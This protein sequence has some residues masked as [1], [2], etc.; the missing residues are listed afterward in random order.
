MAKFLTTN[1]VLFLLV[2][3][4]FLAMPV[5]AGVFF[6]AS[7]TSP[8]GIDVTFNADFTISGDSMTLTLTNDSP[9]DSLNPDEVLTSFFFDIVN[10]NGIRPTLEYSS[11]TGDVYQ[12]VK[13]AADIL[14]EN[15]ADL[16]ALE[17]KDG[18][19]QFKTFDS[20]ID[21][22][23]SFGV[24]TVGNSNISPNN[25]NGN[26]THNGDYGIYKGEISTQPLTNK[27]LVKD[28]AVFTF[29]GLTGFTEADIQPLIAFGIGSGPDGILNP[30]PASVCLLALGGWMLRKKRR[31]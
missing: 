24:G 5:N 3:V 17:T 20:Q 1:N 21:P 8:Q 11:A 30:E 31:G 14:L 28:Q 25:F 9:G 27:V 10:L 4:G 6:T 26:I 7:G 23:L 16:Q 15:D 22:F 29:S 13:D 18:S 12:G 19:W 2:I